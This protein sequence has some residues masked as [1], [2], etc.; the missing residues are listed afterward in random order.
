[1]APDS[2]LSPMDTCFLS[3][4]VIFSLSTFIA[5]FLLYSGK[6]SVGYE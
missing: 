1:M 2:L 3:Y 6:I 5:L 4:A